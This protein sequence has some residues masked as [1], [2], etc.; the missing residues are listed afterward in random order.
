M[1]MDWTRHSAD[2]LRESAQLS[3]SAPQ[4]VAHRVTRMMLAGPQP[5]ARDRREFTLMGAEKLAAFQEAWVAMG[6]RTM[7][8]QQQWALEAMHFW[9]QAALG[10]A[11]LRPRAMQRQVANDVSKAWGSVLDVATR[12][13][14]PVGQRA[15]ANSRRLARTP[16]TRKKR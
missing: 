16:L 11:W 14:R 6:A 9:W 15:A 8:L 13:V 4:V 1:N 2:L 7:A 5:S 3:W 10:G 12:G